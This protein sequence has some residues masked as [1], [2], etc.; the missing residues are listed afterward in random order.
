M[1]KALSREAIK[2]FYILSLVVFLVPV[3]SA[4]TVLVNDDFENSWNGGD[5]WLS[6]WYHQGDSTIVSNDPYEGSYSLTK[7]VM[8]LIL[9]IWMVIQIRCRLFRLHLSL[10]LQRK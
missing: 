6:D 2:L 1:K 5:G 9:I 8:A 4:E 10:L 7:D 3:V